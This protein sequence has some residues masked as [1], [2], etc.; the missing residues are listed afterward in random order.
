[1][2]RIATRGFAS[3]LAP[4]LGSL[5]DLKHAMGFPYDTSER[6]LHGFDAMCAQHHAGEVV[7]TRQM[8]MGWA[9][10]R[11]GEHPNAQLRRI[12]PVRQLAK[13]MIGLGVG[14]FVIPGGIPGRQVR[15]RPHLFSPLQLRALFDAADAVACSRYGGR[16]ELIIPVFFRMIYCLGLRPGEARR[17]HRHDVDLAAGAVHIRESKG[18]RERVV[19]LSGDLHSYCREYDDAIAVHYPDRVAFFPNRAADFYHPSAISHWFGELLTAAGDAIAARP[20]ARPRAYDLRH[21][22]VVE[23]INRWVRAGR[24]PQTLVP[25][26]GAHLGHTSPEHTWYYF[27]LA[28]DFYPDLRMLANTGIEPVLPEAS[29]GIG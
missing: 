25:Y 10:A 7:L 1:M 29:H 11:P 16:R 27:H 8:A 2:S 19:F 6:H 3:G 22:H 17:L 26:L 14:A 20:D 24:D 5:L 23:T 13:H 21:A 9:A 4:Y 15:Y 28:A 18:H 12:T